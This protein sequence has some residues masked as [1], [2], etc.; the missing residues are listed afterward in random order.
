MSEN[1]ISAEDIQ[2]CETLRDA[3]RFVDLFTSVHGSINETDSTN[4]RKLLH[5]A[6]ICKKVW[7]VEFLLQQKET[8]VNVVDVSNE[9]PLLIA[10]RN[11]DFGAVAALHLKGADPEIYDYNDDSPLLWACYNKHLNIVE[12]LV[13][14]MKADTE[15]CYKDGRNALMWSCKQDCFKIVEFLYFKTSCPNLKDMRGNSAYDLARSI[16]IKNFI[17]NQER[18]QRAVLALFYFQNRN[19]ELFEKYTI[20]EVF[21]FLSFP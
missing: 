14:E 10:C 17:H 13:D 2:L 19:H 11:G 21:R 20:T 16:Q 5:W 7:L 4:R 3:E 12:F 18:K 9:S 6:V 8:E 15:H 1:K